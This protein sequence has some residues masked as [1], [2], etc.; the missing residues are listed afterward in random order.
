VH[1]VTTTPTSLINKSEYPPVFDGSKTLRPRPRKLHAAPMPA[2][3][4]VVE[5]KPSADNDLQF[6]PPQ[7]GSLTLK[8]LLAEAGELEDMDSMHVSRFEKLMR[9]TN[10]NLLA[11]QP[12][13]LKL[14][15]ERCKKFLS[16]GSAKEKGSAIRRADFGKARQADEVLCSLE[17]L[18]D[19]WNKLNLR[20]AGA[21]TADTM[22]RKLKPRY[23]AC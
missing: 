3:C 15:S 6:T 12:E 8:Q 17:S 22:R 4:E 11:I 16:A 23:Q 13:T 21:M 19:F 2:A 18:F 9:S 1:T 20:L 10:H 5:A 14:P 7:A